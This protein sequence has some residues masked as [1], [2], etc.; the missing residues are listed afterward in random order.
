MKAIQVITTVDSKKKAKEIANAL[1]NKRL[2]A[3]VQI[4]HVSSAYWWKNKIERAKEWMCVIK[5]RAAVYPKIEVVIKSLHPYSVPEILAFPV[6][7]G[8]KPYLK[9]L[10][11]ET[12]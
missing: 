10:E 5:A 6:I 1:L 12:K 4:F 11:K 9:W 3:C 2:A 7:D 8:N